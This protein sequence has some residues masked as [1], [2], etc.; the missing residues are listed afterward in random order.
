MAEEDKGVMTPATFAK[1]CTTVDFLREDVNNLARAL[2]P[3]QKL[4]P[5]VTNM[6][7]SDSQKELEQ[8]VQQLQS[9]TSKLRTSIFSGLTVI[10]FCFGIIQGGL[11]WYGNRLIARADTDHDRIVMLQTTIDRLQAELSYVQRNNTPRG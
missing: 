9:S 11:V 6:L 3:I 7:N 10:V 1:L 4:I 2:E 5:L 8:E